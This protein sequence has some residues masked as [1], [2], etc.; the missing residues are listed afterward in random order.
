MSGDA[1][2]SIGAEPA[3]VIIRPRHGRLPVLQKEEW[4][5]YQDVHVGEQEAAVGFGRCVDHGFAPDVE[6][7]ID[8][9]RT[10]SEPMKC[11]ENPVKPRRTG[12]RNRL[13]PCGIIHMCNGGNGGSLTGHIA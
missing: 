11:R 13:N 6:R 2:G 8:Q 12:G 3:L 5:H 7:G 4:A 9:C 1:Q 10:A